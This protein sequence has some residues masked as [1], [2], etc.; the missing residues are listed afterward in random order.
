VGLRFLRQNP[1]AEACITKIVPEMG[2]AAGG[3]AGR[4]WGVGKFK[5]EKID[6]KPELFALVRRP[7]QTQGVQYGEDHEAG[8]DKH[9]ALSRSEAF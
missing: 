5:R 7:G 4:S 8:C 9:W 2:R 3:G 1:R 6:V